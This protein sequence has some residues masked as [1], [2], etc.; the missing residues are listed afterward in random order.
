MIHRLQPNLAGTEKNNFL[1]ATEETFE[2][3]P[4]EHIS[5]AILIPHPY[6]VRIPAVLTLE[7]A[8]KARVSCNLHE[9]GRE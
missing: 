5:F 7:L 9:H 6:L 3:K 1:T 2:S 4:A 8:K